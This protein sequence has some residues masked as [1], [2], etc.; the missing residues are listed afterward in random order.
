MKRTSYF[1]PFEV[2][3]KDFMKTSQ[4]FDT[5]INRTMYDYPVDIL[6]TPKGL[7]IEIAAVGLDK[8]DIKIKIEDNDILRVVYFKKERQLSDEAITADDPSYIHRGITRRSFNLGWKVSAK[9]DLEKL[10]AKLDKGLLII[11]IPFSEKSE[12]KTIQIQ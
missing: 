5:V 9:F 8:Q 4:S 11:Q 7:Q 6:E 10:E 1:D 3:F 12:P 2:L